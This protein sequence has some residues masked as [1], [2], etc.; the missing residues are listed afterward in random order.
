MMMMMYVF[1]GSDG[2]H[3]VIFGVW[4][5]ETGFTFATNTNCFS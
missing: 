3:H 4:H 2:T 1:Y 5:Y